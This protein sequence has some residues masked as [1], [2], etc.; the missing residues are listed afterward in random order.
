MS[1][2]FCSYVSRRHPE[3]LARRR[4]VYAACASLAALASHRKSAI[5]DLRTHNPISGRPEIGG[6]PP[7]CG[8]FSY[9]HLVS[10]DARGQNLRNSSKESGSGMNLRAI[11]VDSG[12]LRHLI[13]IGGLS[14]W[15]LVCAAIY[16]GLERLFPGFLLGNARHDDLSGAAPPPA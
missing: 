16:A 10:R 15:V 5:A 14:L 3:E 11:L 6:R 1:S 4:Q 8:P 2:G 9:Q 7:E 13:A 12:A